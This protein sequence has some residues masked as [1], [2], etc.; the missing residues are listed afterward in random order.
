MYGFS[1]K[2]IQNLINPADCSV[3]LV[4]ERKT[5]RELWKKKILLDHS[6]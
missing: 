6:L 2:P 5:T 3:G 1:I 4:P